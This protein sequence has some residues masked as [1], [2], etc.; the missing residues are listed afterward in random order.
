MEVQF[1]APG[2]SL[3]EPS[4]HAADRKALQM[5][6]PNKAAFIRLSIP[7][8]RGEFD[9]FCLDFIT[10]YSPRSLFACAVTFLIIRNSSQ[11]LIIKLTLKVSLRGAWTEMGR[12]LLLVT[13]FR[14]RTCSFHSSRFFFSYFFQFVGKLIKQKNKQKVV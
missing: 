13:L 7:G 3:R 11:N 5:L 8:S 12:C 9:F 1:C 2:G 10:I 6:R 14:A 4:L